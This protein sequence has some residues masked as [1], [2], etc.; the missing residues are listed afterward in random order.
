LNIAKPVVEKLCLIENVQIVAD[1][2]KEKGTVIV[3]NL[4]KIVIDYSANV[5]S[6]AEKKRIHE[7][8]E[9]VNFEIERST[10]ML[11][12]ER[13][14]EKAPKALVEAEK[15]KLAKNKELLNALNQELAKFN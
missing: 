13:F 3:S 15:E 11:A 1:A 9:K 4:C 12:N 10:K 8:I 14:V 2:Q 7:Q 6:E 5:D